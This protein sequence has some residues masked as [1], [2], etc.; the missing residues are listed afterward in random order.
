MKQWTQQDIEFKSNMNQMKYLD[1]K[2]K[3]QK[4]ELDNAKIL[5]VKNNV[6]KVCFYL[7]KDMMYFQA[8]TKSNCVM[9]GVELT[10]CNSDVNRLCLSCAKKHNLCIK[11]GGIMS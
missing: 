8:F 10:F 4:Y 1:L 2:D 3:L 9:C 5:R 7:N 6:C 11:C